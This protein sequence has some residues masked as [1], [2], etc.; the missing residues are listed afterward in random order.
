MHYSKLNEGGIQEDHFKPLTFFESDSEDEIL[1]QFKPPKKE[2][3][4]PKLDLTRAG[5]KISLISSGLPTN[6]I[7]KYSAVFSQQKFG[8]ESPI[9][10]KKP[11]KKVVTV[12][13]GF[14]AESNQDE[15]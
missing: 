12:G 14:D 1:Q 2:K 6:E 13:F 15:T 10:V 8:P 7:T 4:F 11:K 9:A 5:S 3:E